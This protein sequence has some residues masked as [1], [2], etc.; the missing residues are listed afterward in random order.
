M[1]A[2][3]GNHIVGFP[4]GPLKLYVV[5]N[6]TIFDNVVNSIITCIS[7]VLHLGPTDNLVSYVNRSL[8]LI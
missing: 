2:L 6:Y 5:D 1:S 7:S 3:V 8:A 4:T